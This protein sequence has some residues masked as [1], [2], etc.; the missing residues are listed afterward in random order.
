VLKISEEA[1]ADGMSSLE[2]QEDRRWREKPAEK[3]QDGEEPYMAAAIPGG[4]DL[5]RVPPGELTLED[6]KHMSP[7]DGR[8]RWCVPPGMDLDEYIEAIR[9]GVYDNL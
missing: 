5:T 7:R 1:R 2:I 6:L 8:W 9:A 4:R 3:A